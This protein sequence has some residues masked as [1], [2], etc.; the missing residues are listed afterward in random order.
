VLKVQHKPIKGSKLGFKR[1]EQKKPKR[2]LVWRTGLSGVPPDSVRCPG[3]Y[4]FKLATFGFL[5]SRSAI[6][7]RTV[8]CATG[9][10]ALAQRSTPTDTCKSATV[11][12]QF[13][14]SQ[15]SHRRRTGQWTVP[16]RCGTGLS[17]APRCQ[18]SNNRNRQNPNGWV[19]W[20]AHRTVSGGAP[21]CP[22]RPSTD[23]LPNGW[24]GGWGY[25]YPQPPPL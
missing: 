20:L 1:K 6:I 7:H 13:A 5:E 2:T 16:V 4:D 22:M 10:T 9:A 17:G 3:P 21:D 19:M 8:R 25:K 12:R 24:I 18:S 11:H 14:Q 23:S 15:S